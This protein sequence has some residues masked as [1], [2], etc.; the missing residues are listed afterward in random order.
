MST[1]QAKLCAKWANRFRRDATAV[2]THLNEAPASPEMLEIYRMACLSLA[3]ELEDELAKHHNAL[4][5]CR[6]A[7]P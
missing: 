7:M 1:Q 4:L 3:N 6:R 2:R 5:P